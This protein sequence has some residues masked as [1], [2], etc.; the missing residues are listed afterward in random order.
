MIASGTNTFTDHLINA[1][2]PI[3]DRKITP[4]K[5]NDWI[6]V[7][8][9]LNHPNKKSIIYRLVYLIRLLLFQLMYST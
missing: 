5:I 7:G 3:I 8:A 6:K 9:L 4:I 1:I 2:N